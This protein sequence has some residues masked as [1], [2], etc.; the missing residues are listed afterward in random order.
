M[1]F[2]LTPVRSPTHLTGPPLV[3]DRTLLYVKHSTCRE[4]WNHLEMLKINFGEKHSFY[5]GSTKRYGIYFTGAFQRRR[6]DV[7]CPSQSQMSSRERMPA[8][9]RHR[10]TA[11][12]LRIFVSHPG[13]V[14]WG[15]ISLGSASSFFRVI[16]IFKVVVFNNPGKRDL[17]LGWPCLSEYLWTSK[18]GLSQRYKLR[19][20]L[21]Y[22]LHSTDW[23]S[24]QMKNM[25][26][27]IWL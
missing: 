3:K 13:G 7:M 10:S 17:R 1:L 11:M 4:V 26:M 2:Y 9:A 6:V 8:A 12:F 16:K 25:M 22:L 20:E 5:L 14:S 19:K 23:N 21:S 24:I 27:L 15:I 18:S